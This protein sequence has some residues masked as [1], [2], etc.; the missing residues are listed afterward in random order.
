MGERVDHQSGVQTKQQ[1]IT[2]GH[3]ARHQQGTNVAVCTRLI[4]YHHRLAQTLTKAVSNGARAAIG[5][6]TSA[7]GHDQADGFV[8]VVLRP[9]SAAQAHQPT[10]HTDQHP[11]ADYL[12]HM[13]N[14]V[15]N[16]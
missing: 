8:G 9:S 3:R 10:H 2:I 16:R 1:G 5:R 12:S 4:F 11:A 7:K 14:L 6:T 13:Q 15:F